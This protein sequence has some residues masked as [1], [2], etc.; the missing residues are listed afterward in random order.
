[1]KRE[2]T[3]KEQRGDG[4]KK[5]GWGLPSLKCGCPRH[6]WLATCLCNT[7]LSAA[8][9]HLAADENLSECSSSHFSA[10]VNLSY[11]CLRVMYFAD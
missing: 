8:T 3:E 1:M 10:F 2:A 4:R 7:L 11:V 9:I 6:H 5:G